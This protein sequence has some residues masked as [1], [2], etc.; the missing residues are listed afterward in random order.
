[1]LEDAQMRFFVEQCFFASMIL[2]RDKVSKLHLESICSCNLAFLNL[3]KENLHGPVQDL[4]RAKKK[5]FLRSAQE[6]RD[7]ES[8]SH[9][10]LM[11]LIST[12]A[13][14]SRFSSMK[15][16]AVLGLI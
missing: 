15:G 6:R 2:Q 7:K 13:P 14:I 12:I 10:Y 8:Q 3:N 4:T 5:T 9:P 1:V 11:L 16:F